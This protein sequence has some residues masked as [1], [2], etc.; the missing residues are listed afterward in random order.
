MSKSVKDLVLSCNNFTKIDNGEIKKMSTKKDIKAIDLLIYSCLCHQSYVIGSTNFITKSFLSKFGIGRYQFNSSTESLIN[1]GFI[2]IHGAGRGNQRLE[3]LHSHAL[4][5]DFSSI[6]NALLQAKKDILTLSEKAFII[7]FWKHIQPDG[8]HLDLDYHNCTIENV[9]GKFASMKWYDRN[10]KSLSDKGVIKI[11][12]SNRFW[13]AL[14]FHKVSEIMGVV[15][16]EKDEANNVL[17]QENL[18]L[19]TQVRELERRISQ[20]KKN[21]STPKPNNV[22]DNSSPKILKKSSYEKFD[23]GVELDW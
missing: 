5:K 12:K 21:K 6:S 13:F 16:L 20:P 3:I 2:K 7:I 1:G 4:S 10:K 19:K 18:V 23:Y 8:N 14:D 22:E 15:G 11:E 9:L 17:Q